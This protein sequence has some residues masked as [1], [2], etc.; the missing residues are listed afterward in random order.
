MLLLFGRGALSVQKDEAG[1]ALGRALGEVAL[2]QEGKA[3]RAHL[4]LSRDTLRALLLSGSVAS[5][6]SAK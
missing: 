2:A 3:L 4:P 5:G 6:R 1:R